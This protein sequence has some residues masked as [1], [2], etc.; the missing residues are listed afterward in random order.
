VQVVDT[1]EQV[2]IGERNGELAPS[3]PA[4]VIVTAY[5]RVFVPLAAVTTMVTALVPMSSATAGEA[6]PLETTA[7]FTAIVA[8][9][10]VAVAV[11]VTLE[12]TLATLD[13]YAAT[14][15]AKAGD[16]V[17]SLIVSA[18][19]VASASGDTPSSDPHARSGA[20]P[21]MPI[22]PSAWRRET[23]RPWPFGSSLIRI[24]SCRSSPLPPG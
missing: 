4:R 19:S 1:L 24:S 14:P 13:V 9:L 18:R 2:D 21:R 11:T 8:P 12:T 17:A 15:L 22:L 7:L 5:A 23:A 16:S 10:C 6:T 20:E 3:T